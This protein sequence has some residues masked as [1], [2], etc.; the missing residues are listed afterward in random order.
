VFVNKLAIAILGLSSLLLAGTVAEAQTAR[1]R[2][3]DTPIR[4]E[5][6]L[7]SAII[8]TVKEG[9][10]VD[11]V[12][13]QSDWYSVL[14]PN[15]QGQRRVGFVLASLIDMVAADGSPQ[16]ILPT[17][18]AARPIA[19]GPP[20]A[21]TADQATL[22]REG[23]ERERA[24]K[25]R[26]DALQAD[27]D[28]LQSG[29][30]STSTQVR[31]GDILRAVPQ[32]LQAREGLWFNAGLGYGSLGCDTCVGTLGGGSGGLSFG[33]TISERLRVGVGTMGYYRSLEDSVALSAST[34]GA[35]VHFY[36]IRTSGFLLTG[37]VGVG[38]ISAAARGLGSAS[39]TGLGVV[40]GVGWD[41]RVGSKVS[42]TPFWN[43]FTVRTSNLAANVGQLGLA[44][45]V[46]PRDSQ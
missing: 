7:A 17:N 13:L 16:A 27:L 11:V 26:V 8:A 29:E 33:W 35:L 19:Y 31:P 10:P 45:T 40:F 38:T 2:F 37:G 21:P 9:S 20:I 36:P 41:V 28:A 43:G 15:E 30:P 46:H 39:E 6:N 3:A 5:A 25:A 18:R 23:A 44:I 22:L 4:A 14:V 12:D 34:L 24:L 42:L 32:P 1:A